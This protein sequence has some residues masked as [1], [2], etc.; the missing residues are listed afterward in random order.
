MSLYTKIH[1]W[2]KQIGKEDFV[3]ILPVTWEVGKV[4]SSLFYNVPTG[5]PFNVSIPWLFKWLFDPCDPRFLKAA[6]LH[7]HMLE[8][9]W[10]RTTAAGVFND[11]LM[12]EGVS[13][14]ERWAMFTAVAWFKWK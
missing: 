10:D 4:G 1:D 5:F 13:R 8:N 2:C 3:T 6:C 7:D 11:A 12:A 9:G 14:L